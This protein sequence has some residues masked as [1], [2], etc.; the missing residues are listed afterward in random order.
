MRKEYSKDSF[1]FKMFM[2]LWGII[3]E[4]GIVEQNEEYWSSLANAARSFS[5]KYGPWAQ[6]LIIATIEEFERRTEETKNG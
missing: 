5:K 2:E 6:A 3:K 4:Y 1:E